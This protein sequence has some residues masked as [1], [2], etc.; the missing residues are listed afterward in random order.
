M[1]TNSIAL[2]DDMDLPP[3]FRALA[4]A[5]GAALTPLFTEQT[6]ALADRF[7]AALKEN[8][9]G[10]TSQVQNQHQHGKGKPCCKGCES[11]GSCELGWSGGGCDPFAEHIDYGGTSTYVQSM[12]QKCRLCRTIDPCIVWMYLED[13]RDLDSAAWEQLLAKDGQLVHIDKY[14]GAAP[15]QDVPLP[16]NK[17]AIFTQSDEQQLSYWPEIIKLSP[18]WNGTPVPSKVVLRWFTGDKG[19]TALTDTTGLIQIGETQTLADYACG[20]S[21]YVVPFPKVKLCPMGH[22]PRRRAVYLEVETKSIGGATVTGI[23]ATIIKRGTEMWER[24]APLCGKAYG[25]CAK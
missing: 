12:L 10:V 21:C 20:D 24:W 5:F 1:A 9:G 4:S 17:K 22:I 11:G 23:N 2:S 16:S 18:D 25:A 15:Y 19:L 3:H 13:R 6:K 7:C 8:G 14:V